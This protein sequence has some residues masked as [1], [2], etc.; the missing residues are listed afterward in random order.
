MPTATD[1]EA[2]A[3]LSLIDLTQPRAI[4]ARYERT[5]AVFGELTAAWTVA[6]NRVHDTGPARALAAWGKTHAPTCVISSL[7]GHAKTVECAAWGADRGALMLR[8]G[9]ADGWPWGGGPRARAVERAEV[10]VVDDL[11][12]ENPSSQGGGCLLNALASRHD[13]GRRTLA[14]A[15]FSRAEAV[16]RYP[17]HWIERVGR[18]WLPVRERGSL[19]HG[20][21]PQLEGLAHARRTLG[22]AARAQHIAIRV[23]HAPSGDETLAELATAFG[24][25]RGRV[26]DRA[27]QLETQR[28]GVDAL[29]ATAAARFAELAAEE[30]AGES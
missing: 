22:L 10:V 27:K 7:P 28:A 26:L 19:R 12:R 14:S 30:I 2:A 8:A 16:K 21:E 17:A 6:D 11:G 25:D 20:P 5:R 4:V 13:A 15:M 24:L 9:E 18:N 29:A 3:L 23:V 1:L